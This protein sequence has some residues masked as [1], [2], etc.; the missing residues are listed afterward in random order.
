MQQ[1][2]AARVFGTVTFNTLSCSRF[3]AAPSVLQVQEL[4]QAALQG[5]R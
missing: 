4:L 2:E 5:D 1:I 3:G